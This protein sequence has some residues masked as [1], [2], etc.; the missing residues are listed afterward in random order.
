M[1]SCKLSIKHAS[2]ARDLTI[3][4]ESQHSAT[5]RSY[6]LTEKNNDDN[7]NTGK[8]EIQNT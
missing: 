7:I 4:D 8:S 1:D 3:E 5:Q 6:K 2:D